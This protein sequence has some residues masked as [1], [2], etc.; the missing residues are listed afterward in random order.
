MQVLFFVSYS[1]DDL[2]LLTLNNHP[3][4]IRRSVHL[5]T[6]EKRF[7]TEKE[8]PI[9]NNLAV[10]TK[11]F[12]PQEQYVVTLIHVCVCADFLVDALDYAISKL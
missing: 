7:C 3:P 12:F 10:L 8:S 2:C 5:I 11:C 1:F 9:Y 6:I 4:L